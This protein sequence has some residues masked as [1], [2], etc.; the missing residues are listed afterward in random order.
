V[1]GFLVVVAVEWLP[2]FPIVEPV[3][4]LPVPELHYK[5]VPLA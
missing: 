3:F 2:T 4:E 1:G 5:K